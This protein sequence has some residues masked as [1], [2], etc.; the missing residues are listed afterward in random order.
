MIETL[1]HEGI[2]IERIYYCPHHPKALIKKY[3]KECRCRKPQIGLF[4]I[5]CRELNID[6]GRSIAVGDRLRDLEIARISDCKGYLIGNT[7]EKNVILS[8]KKGQY[9]NI[10]YADSLYNVALEMFAKKK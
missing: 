6:L 7:E 10:S 1:K 5:A 3:R 9:R 2:I 4:E 8:V